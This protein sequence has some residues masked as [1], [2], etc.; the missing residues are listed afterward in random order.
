MAPLTAPEGLGRHGVG[1]GLSLAVLA[2]GGLV[3]GVAAQRRVQYVQEVPVLVAG[4]GLGM[5]CNYF[6]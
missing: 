1:R 3:V 2:R 6:Y 5:T 4:A